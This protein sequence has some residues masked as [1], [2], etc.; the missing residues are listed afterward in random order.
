MWDA[1]RPH[2]AVA[3]ARPTHFVIREAHPPPL[4]HAVGIDR[5]RAGDVERSIARVHAVRPKHAG[6]DRVCDPEASHRQH[7][8]RDAKRERYDGAE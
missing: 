5:D 2:H 8:D 1:E 3:V 7:A 6:Q 4:L